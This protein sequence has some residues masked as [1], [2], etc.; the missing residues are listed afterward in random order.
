MK[1]KFEIQ[2]IAEF[3]ANLFYFRRMI[4]FCAVLFFVVGNVFYMIAPVFIFALAG[5]GGAIFIFISRANYSLLT[6]CRSKNFPSNAQ[7]FYSLVDDELWNL[8]SEN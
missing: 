5:W 7:E 2:K 6:T 1:N 3:S 4:D 8:I